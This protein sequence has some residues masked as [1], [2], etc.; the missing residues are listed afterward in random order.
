M[1]ELGRPR[2]WLGVWAFGWALCIALSL[3]PTLPLDGPPG[4]DKLGH[5]LAYFCLAAWAAMLFRGAGALARAG[6]ALFLLGA[7][8]EILQAT[9]TE[10]RQGD[11]RDLLANG[12]GVFAGL[13]VA[14]TPLARL[15]ERIDPAGPRRGARPG[16]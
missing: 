7:S 15:L 16:P 5:F 13:M 2:W 1:R 6:L 14:A 4:S 3:G 11:L 8:L 10:S 12:A 9:L